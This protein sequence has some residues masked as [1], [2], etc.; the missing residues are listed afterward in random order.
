MN[1]EFRNISIYS[2]YLRNHGKKNTFEKL[3]GDL[4]RIKSMKFDVIWLLPIHPIGII[5]KKGDLGCPYSIKDFGDV[6]S[7]YGDMDSFKDFIDAAHKE[8]LKVMID[9]VYNHTSYDSKLFGEHPE[10]FITDEKG[11]PMCKAEDWIDVI[12]LDYD[13]KDI[14]QPMIG[15]LKKWSMLGVDGYRCDVASLVPVEFWKTAREEVA[16]INPDTIWLAESVNK[17]FIEELVEKGFKAYG[18]K[19]VYE[20]FDI[21]YDY[22]IHP[23]YEAFVKGEISLKEYIDEVKNQDELYL[24]DYIK[25]RFI[26]N[27]DQK[28]MSAYVDSIEKK[29]NYTVLSYMLKGATLVYAGQETMD[30][31]TPSLFDIDPVN[32][33]RII[34]EYAKLIERLNLLVKDEV[35]KTKKVSYEII[36]DNLLIVRYEDDKVIAAINFGDKEIECDF[37]LEGEY[38]EVLDDSILTDVGKLKIIKPI[39]MRRR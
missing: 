9:V 7:E 34:P 29:I 30:T 23:Q 33:D 20:A 16:N 21:L 3:I 8:G 22:D 35:F 32:F 4:K 6:N 31:H 19:E 37:N 28:R 27:H 13:N 38:E 12:D 24:D 26:E 39:I 14:W 5:N 2:I 10:Y 15:Y 17:E 1:S 18:D 36:K 25:L 11:K